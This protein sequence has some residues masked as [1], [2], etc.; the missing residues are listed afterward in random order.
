MLSNPSQSHSLFYIETERNDGSLRTTP[1]L[2]ETAKLVLND[3]ACTT[4][5]THYI[6]VKRREDDSFRKI[7]IGLKVMESE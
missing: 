3:Q 4:F 6:S 1:S 2:F 7:V 5:S